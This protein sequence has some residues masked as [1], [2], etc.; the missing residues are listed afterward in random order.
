MQCRSRSVLSLIASAAIT[1]AAGCSPET[2]A[3]GADVLD[4]DPTADA[5][6]RGPDTIALERAREA[7]AARGWMLANPE[8]LSRVPRA[9]RDLAGLAPA[10]ALDAIARDAGFRAQIDDNRVRFVRGAPY[11]VI[12][13]R[14]QIDLLVLDHPVIDILEQIANAGSVELEVEPGLDL[15]RRVSMNF[16]DV[17]IRTVLLLLASETDTVITPHADGIRV[18]RAAPRPPAA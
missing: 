10:E 11:A 7:S 2:S 8:A 6:T 3:P 9:R 13:D 17:P 14:G 15:Q 18:H 4:S 16:T 12:N 1:M 5:S